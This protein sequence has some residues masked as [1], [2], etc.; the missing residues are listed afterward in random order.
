MD[1]TKPEFNSGGDGGNHNT[2]EVFSKMLG[3]GDCCREELPDWE[4]G[5]NCKKIDEFIR[6]HL[7]DDPLFTS[8][9]GHMQSADSNTAWTLRGGRNLVN[10]NQLRLNNCYVAP[11]VDGW[12]PFIGRGR[13]D[14]MTSCNGFTVGIDRDETQSFNGLWIADAELVKPTGDLNFPIDYRN[15]RKYEPV[16]YEDYFRVVARPET[17]MGRGMPDAYIAM[18]IIGIVSSMWRHFAH[19]LSDESKKGIVSLGDVNIKQLRDDLH[20]MGMIEENG[21]IDWANGLVLLH[22]QGVDLDYL[23]ISAL[24]ESMKDPRMFMDLVAMLYASIVKVDVNQVWQVQS[25]SFGNSAEARASSQGST[26]TGELEF[27]LTVQKQ[28]NNRVLP[29]SVHFEFEERDAKSEQDTAALHGLYL[30]NAKCIADLGFGQAAAQDY[31]IQNGVVDASWATE[32]AATDTEASDTE[33]ARLRDSVIGLV[34]QRIADGLPSEA[35]VEYN[36]RTGRTRTL[37][38]SHEAVLKPRIH[39]VPSIRATLFQ[40]SVVKIVDDDQMTLEDEIK[41]WIAEADENDKETFE[42]LL[43]LLTAEDGTS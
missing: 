22:G 13:H 10:R 17:K 12:N 21:E 7:C 23:P 31:A 18:K 26:N 43:A 39:A 14:Y 27:L 20:E 9:I 25:G 37:F 15:G 32:P 1:R 38:E 41:E 3:L 36:S 29:P 34:H 8:F 16:A 2:Y 35:I 4:D 19:D 28:L 6:K 24:P 42:I 30:D 5:K 33:Q 11:D 40:D